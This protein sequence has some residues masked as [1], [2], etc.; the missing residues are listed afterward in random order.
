MRL[1]TKQERRI[2]YVRKPSQCWSEAITEYKDVVRLDFTY[3][4]ARINLGEELTQNGPRPRGQ[5]K[6]Y[7]AVCPY[8][9]IFLREQGREKLQQLY[10]AGTING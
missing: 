3:A 7:F 4:E 5:G 9:S 6:S 10:S 8:F 2:P 1:T